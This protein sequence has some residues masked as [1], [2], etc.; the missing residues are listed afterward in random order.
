MS[1]FLE[2]SLAVGFMFSFF[3]DRLS[4]CNK[5][6]IELEILFPQPPMCWDCT[7]AHHAQLVIYFKSLYAIDSLE[8]SHFAS[9]GSFALV[10][11]KGFVCCVLFS[12]S[13]LPIYSKRSN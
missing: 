6:G 11:L 2:G 13:C 5:A 1:F 3:W 12:I 8:P 10:R 4:L 7:Y 9:K